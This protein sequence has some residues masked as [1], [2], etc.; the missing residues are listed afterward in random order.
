MSEA[1]D[2]VDRHNPDR[3]CQKFAQS[4][5]LRHAEANPATLKRSSAMF[6]LEF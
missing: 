1:T 5:V 3:R 6:Q 4:E 2:F